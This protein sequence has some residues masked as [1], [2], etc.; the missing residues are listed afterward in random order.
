MNSFFRAVTL[1]LALILDWEKTMGNNG[2]ND[3]MREL[4]RY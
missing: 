2:L 1:L 3:R 4:N